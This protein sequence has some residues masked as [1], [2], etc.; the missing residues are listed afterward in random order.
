VRTPLPATRTLTT[1]V[2]P[3][4]VT[5]AIADYYIQPVR[6]S[7]RGDNDR[8]VRI[9]TAEAVARM[10]GSSVR[11]PLRGKL[12]F[13]RDA[14]SAEGKNANKS[15]N[16][17]PCSRVNRLSMVK[18][19]FKKP[20]KYQSYLARCPRLSHPSFGLCVILAHSRE[21]HANHLDQEGI[22][23]GGSGPPFSAKR[24]E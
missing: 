20:K 8:V 23:G 17:G 21:N 18:E 7:G 24:M 15:E 10:R 1:C 12:I 3:S 19:T 11:N 4:T 14:S 22:R 6:A 2:G 13:I 16:R 5:N 9:T